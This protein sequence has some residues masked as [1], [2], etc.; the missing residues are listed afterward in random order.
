LRA[1]AERG[2]PTA[3][4]EFRYRNPTPPAPGSIT[5]R[6]LAG[7]PFIHVA[8]VKDHYLYRRGDPHRRALVDLG[9]A[10]TFLS[11]T[12]LKD[13][14]PV[15]SINI[16]RQEVKPFSDKQIA[17]LQNFAAQAVIAMENARLITETREALEQQT[18]TAEVF[19]VINGS[20]GDL[21][22]VFDAIL[23]KA[24]TLCGAAHGSLQLYDGET[25][26]A[27]ATHAV[28]DEFAEILRQGYRAADSLASRE[29]PDGKSFI[30]IAD[31]AEIEHPVVRSAAEL[32]GIR[33]LLVV[34][35]RKDRALLGLISATRLEVRLFTDKQIALLQ[36]FAAQAVVAMENARLITETR[37]ALDQQTAT[38]RY[39]RSSI[40]R[41]ATSPRCSTRCSK[42]RCACAKQRSGRFIPLMARQ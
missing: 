33:T 4:T 12:L 38:A 17:L 5:A 36:N 31:C 42:R 6:I 9:G 34:A 14:T 21:A 41:P 27:V 10:R 3:F 18:A 19:G 35:L 26:H 1:V 13:R 25:L 11:V 24:H 22:P 16:Y 39:C 28:P 37:E 40:R 20:P 15:G 23:E 30:Q 29:L 2:A 32:V 7:E 8:D